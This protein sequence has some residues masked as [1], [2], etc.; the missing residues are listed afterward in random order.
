[1]TSTVSQLSEYLQLQSVPEEFVLAKRANL[2]FML[3]PDNFITNVLGTR[4]N[5]IQQGGY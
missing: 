5:D 4:Y 2:F 1:M 3:N